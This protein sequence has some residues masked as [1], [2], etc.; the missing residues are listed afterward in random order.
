MNC[1]LSSLSCTNLGTYA[2]QINF[3]EMSYEELF[4]VFLPAEGRLKGASQE[5]LKGLPYHEVTEHNKMDTCGDSICCTVCLQVN[6]SI[7]NQSFMVSKVCSDLFP[8]II[9]F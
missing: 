3:S 7:L 6:Y 5:F 8:R 4:E 9:S 2:G 1:I